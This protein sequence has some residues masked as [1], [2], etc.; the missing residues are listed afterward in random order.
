MLPK[1]HALRDRQIPHGPQLRQVRSS[2]FDGRADL[3]APPRKNRSET[4]PASLDS[5]A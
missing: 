4:V 1:F 5:R 3:A 2:D